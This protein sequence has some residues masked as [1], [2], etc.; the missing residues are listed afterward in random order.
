LPGFVYNEAAIPR[1]EKTKRKPR[2]EPWKREKGSQEVK[3]QK[4]KAFGGV[5][6]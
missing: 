4:K 2:T 5:K 3:T 6:G 1:A